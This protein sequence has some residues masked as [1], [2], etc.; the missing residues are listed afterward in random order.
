[1]SRAV[2]VTAIAALAAVAA[3]HALYPRPGTPAANQLFSAGG[4]AFLVLALVA[5]L[6]DGTRRRRSSRDGSA[7]GSLLDAENRRETFRIPYPKEERPALRLA[8]AHQGISAGQALAVIDL[9]EEGAR[10]SIPPG[11]ALR[12]V[13]QGEIRFPGGQV[14]PVTGR[15][16]RCGDGEAALAFARALPAELLLEEQ[17]RLRA[18]LRPDRAHSRTDRE[19]PG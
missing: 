17:R 15:A 9:S 2:V 18:Y 10:A 14:V 11:A 8:G 19:A 12:G 13:V 16:I 6:W 1:M 3:H 5:V 4:L 7:T